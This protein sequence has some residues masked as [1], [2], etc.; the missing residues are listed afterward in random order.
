MS[1]KIILNECAARRCGHIYFGGETECLPEDDRTLPGACPRCGEPDYYPLN[2]LGQRRKSSDTT[3]YTMGVADINPSPRMGPKRR[4]RIL[5][6]KRRAEG[7]EPK[8]R[9]PK[10]GQCG[11]PC[12]HPCADYMESLTCTNRGGP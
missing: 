9:L 2:P 5:A 6:A 1:D 3:A 8:D 12:E 11:K 4:C 10:C 7:R